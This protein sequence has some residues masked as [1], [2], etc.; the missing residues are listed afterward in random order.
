MV[1]V[2]HHGKLALWNK[3]LVHG[4]YEIKALK[5][6]QKMESEEIRVYWGSELL[7]FLFLDNLSG[8]LK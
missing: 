3:E 8:L 6:T 2:Q 1:K 4:Q 5:G 7:S